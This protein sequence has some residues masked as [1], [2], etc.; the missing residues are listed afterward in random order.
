MNRGH[1][2]PPETPEAAAGE[3]FTEIRRAEE[4]KGQNRSRGNRRSRD[5]LLDVYAECLARPVA[6]NSATVRRCTDC[7]GLAAECSDNLSD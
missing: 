1:V 4:K 5:V 3:L 2:H 7:R 6:G